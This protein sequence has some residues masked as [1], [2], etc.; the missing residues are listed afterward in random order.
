MENIEDIN[1]MFAYCKLL[2]SI[3]DIS[4]WNINENKI[5]NI[6]HL[7]YGCSSLSSLPNI[8]KWNIYKN[9]FSSNMF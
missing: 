6:N 3:P 2:I 1:N 4:N 5:K 9:L 7:F 8:L